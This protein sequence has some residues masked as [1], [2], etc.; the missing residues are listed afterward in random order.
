MKQQ[1]TV[2]QVTITE[3]IISEG[4]SSWIWHL[5]KYIGPFG[6]IV[7]SGTASSEWEALRDAKALKAGEKARREPK[8]YTITLEDD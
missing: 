7:G 8:K 2:Y 1:E 6:S 3:E 4:K 5:Q